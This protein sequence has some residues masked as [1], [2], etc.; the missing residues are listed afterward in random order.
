MSEL[1][2]TLREYILSEF[3]PGEDPQE[4]VADTSLDGILDSFAK[5]SL[6]TFIEE[7]FDIVL[8]PADMKRLTSVAEITALIESKRSRLEP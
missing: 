1:E 4:L 3:L 6:V 5:L 7:R 2:S 8:E